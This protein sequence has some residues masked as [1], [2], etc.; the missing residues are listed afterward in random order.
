MK[1]S[2]LLLLFFFLFLLTFT[3]PPTCYWLPSAQIKKVS[4]PMKAEETGTQ[5]IPRGT[6]LV[7]YSTI[8]TQ[9]FLFFFLENYEQIMGQGY[10]TSP[11]KVC[12]TQTTAWLSS[13][14]RKCIFQSHLV[15]RINLSAWRAKQEPLLNLSLVTT[16]KLPTWTPI[17]CSNSSK[18]YF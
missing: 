9:I 13:R 18:T 4:M 8:V 16:V 10:R 1:L 12:W 11:E 15:K 14:L 5:N 2:V 3:C 6:T 7:W 17:L